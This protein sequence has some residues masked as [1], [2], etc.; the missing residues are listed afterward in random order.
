MPS[1]PSAATIARSIVRTKS[2]HALDGHDRVGHQLAGPV[3]GHAPAAVGLH[4]LDALGR[5]QSSPIGRSAGSVRLPARVDGRVL[6]HEQHVGNSPAPRRRAALLEREGLRGRARGQ[7]VRP[8]ARAS[9]KATL[10]PVRPRGALLAGP[11]SLAAARGHGCGRLRGAHAARRLILLTCCRRGHRVDLVP[12]ILLATF[13]N[14]VL[15]GAVGPWLARRIWARRPAADPGAPPRRSS[16]CSPTA[17]APACSWR[18]WSAC[19]PPAL[20]RGRRWSPRP[21]P[22]SEP[23]GSCRPSSQRSGD[24]ELI[25]NLETANTRPPRRGLLPHLHRARR[26]RALL[27]LLPRHEQAEPTRSTATRA[28]SRTGSE[29]RRRRR[30]SAAQPPAGRTSNSSTRL[31]PGRSALSGT[32]IEKYSVRPPAQPEAPAHR[33]D[34]AVDRHGEVAHRLGRRA[35][36]PAGHPGRQDLRGRVDVREQ[37]RVCHLARRPARRAT[38]LPPPARPSSSG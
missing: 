3:V 23:P 13:G 31:R 11:R 38:A 37:R 6:E 28:P 10:R 16:R 35:G 9:P 30:R 22:R 5:Y 19:S 29:A 15:V 34:S 26:P 27:L 14:L 21:T 18:A 12:A 2:G 33:A 20:P 25:R 4:D 8:R 24:A 36:Q 7:A 17:S 1:S 32:N